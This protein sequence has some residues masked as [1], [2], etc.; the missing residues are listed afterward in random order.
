[1]LRTSLFAFLLIISVS[2]VVAETPQETAAWEALEETLDKAERGDISAIVELGRHYFFGDMMPR[3]YE[4]AIELW[5]FAIGVGG[6]K[7]ECQILG[8]TH[9]KGVAKTADGMFLRGLAILQDW[10]Y[11]D[12]SETPAAFSLLHRAGQL[13]IDQGQTESAQLMLGTLTLYDV[14]LSR[15]YARNLFKQ[16]SK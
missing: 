2:H 1:M 11:F 9:P 15:K 7:T 13:Y 16:L 4:K 12:G 10:C 8:L 3:D 14:P 5:S 6:Q